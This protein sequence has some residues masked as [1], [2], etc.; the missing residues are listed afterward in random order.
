ML[1]SSSCQ[2]GL[3]DVAFD[4]AAGQP[5]T[6]CSSQ[7][8]W[9]TLIPASALTAFNGQ[10]VTGN[11]NLIIGD[12]GSPKTGTLVSWCV[13][14]TT[15]EVCP[16]G[17]VTGSEGCDDNNVIS[18]DGC[19]NCQV[20]FGYDCANQPSVCVSICGDGERASG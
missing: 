1:A 18:D 8:P 12:K 9:P 2:T 10:V 20:D 5:S 4:D 6:Y 13:T 14:I 17:L 19:S 7:T 15:G 16:D 3:G 11:W